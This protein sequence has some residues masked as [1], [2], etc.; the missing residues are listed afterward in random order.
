MYNIDTKYDW[1]H[2]DGNF[3]EELTNGTYFTTIND[4]MNWLYKAQKNGD[5]DGYCLELKTYYFPNQY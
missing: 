3:V 2:S 5:M 1:R 4:A